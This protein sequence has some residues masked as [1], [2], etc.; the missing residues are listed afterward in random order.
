MGRGKIS[1][2]MIQAPG[3]QVEAKKKMK[4][5]MKAIWALTAGMLLAME[6]PAS[7]R[8]VL[9]NPTVTPMMATRNWQINMPKAPQRRSGRRPNLST[10]Q[11]E[12][13]VEQT[14]TKVK[15][16]EIRKVL[17]MAP[18]DCRKGVE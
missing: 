17:L 6:T 12:I 7:L 16:S 13:G 4:M 18:V 5:A 3:P 2:I 14:F 9:L 15:I 8:W 11:K 1:P 10:D